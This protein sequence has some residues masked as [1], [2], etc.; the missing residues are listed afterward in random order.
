MAVPLPVTHWSSSLTSKTCLVSAACTTQRPSHSTS[1]AQPVSG[2]SRTAKRSVPNSF[3]AA[4][5]AAK[6]P[7]LF[8]LTLAVCFPPF[9]AV[10]G[11]A[12][13][14]LSTR[15]WQAA[16]RCQINPLRG[17]PARTRSTILLAPSYCW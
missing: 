11:T 6:L 2:S 5:S 17:V 9:Y 1:P 15:S 4:V 16:S 12:G 10:N 14:R 8:L 3:P 13:P 7:L